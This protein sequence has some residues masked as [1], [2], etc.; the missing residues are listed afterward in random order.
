MECKQD[1]ILYIPNPKYPAQ[2]NNANKYT[3]VTEPSNLDTTP[4]DSTSDP[5]EAIDTNASFAVDFGQLGDSQISQDLIYGKLNVI[6]EG[7]KYHGFITTLDIIHLPLCLF[8]GHTTLPG[9]LF[10]YSLHQSL[11][12]I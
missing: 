1:T 9:H 3:I 8:H 7:Q 6:N 5:T 4:Y 11:P 12:K 10:I 2:E